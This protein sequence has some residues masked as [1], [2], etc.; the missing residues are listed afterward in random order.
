MLTSHCES[1]DDTSAC[2]NLPDDSHFK[3]RAYLWVR[4]PLTIYKVGQLANNYNTQESSTLHTLRLLSKIE[5]ASRSSLWTTTSAS[6]NTQQGPKI[7]ESKK[8]KPIQL[9]GR[10]G[11]G[12]G[13][14]VRIACALAAVTSQP[15]RVFHVRGNREG[16]R[17]GGTR[18]GGEFGPPMHSAS[19]VYC[20][21]SLY[22]RDLS[23]STP[24][25][26][27]RP[28][29]PARDGCPV[30]CGRDGRRGRRP[31]SRQPHSGVPAQGPAYGAALQPRG[32]KDQHRRR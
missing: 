17:G 18:G 12:G 16:P 3:A 23:D 11:E 19:L 24:W 25:P 30:A 20:L 26:T 32:R 13:Q 6:H 5:V 1:L 8:K 2:P 31:R 28:E 21:I 4:R 9:D 7:M 14:L 10:T 27:C 15:I 22:P 29:V